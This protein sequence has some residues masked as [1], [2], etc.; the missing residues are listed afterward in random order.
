VIKKDW[1]KPVWI[2]SKRPV[3]LVLSKKKK[4]IKK[5]QNF[6]LLVLTKKNIGDILNIVATK[7]DT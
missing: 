3:M 1:K 5:I 6:S 2:A 4:K 7:C